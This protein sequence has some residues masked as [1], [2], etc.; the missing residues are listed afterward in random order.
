VTRHAFQEVLSLGNF[1]R[2]SGW[3]VLGLLLIVVVGYLS[4]SHLDVGALMPV[5]SAIV[6]QPVGDLPV[7]PE[8]PVP[9]SLGFDGCPPE[10]KGGSPQL[11]MLLNRVDKGN[12]QPVSIDSL[13]ALTWPKNVELEPMAA[14]SESNRA[15][16]SQYLGIPVVVEGYIVNLREGGSYPA[17]CNEVDDANPFWRI[18]LAKN[19]R[20]NRAQA[21][22]A[23]STPQARFG[24]TWTADF[25]RSF[26]IAGRWQVR[27]S[28]WLYFNPDHPQ[29]VGRTRA[30]LWEIS[31]VMQIEVFEDGHWNQLDKYNK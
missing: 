30:T 23:V 29:D 3:I 17:N 6:A 7:M 5:G 22:V 27:I 2:R 4:F 14:W 15:F 25:I 19:P 13:L 1:L 28:G 11:N 18:Y 9:D 16:I 12:Y 26:L 21:L 8:K 20:D 24:H 10:G 31:P